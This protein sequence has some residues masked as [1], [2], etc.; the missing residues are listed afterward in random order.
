MSHT[1]QSIAHQFLLGVMER[2]RVKYAR[3]LHK[4]KRNRIKAQQGLKPADKDHL[5][6]ALEAET[7]A[8]ERTD[9]IIL[10]PG[11]HYSKV[12]HPVCETVFI[13]K[14]KTVH[15]STNHTNT[16]NSGGVLH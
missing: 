2:E 6:V 11:N 13:S 5:I 1:T 14:T 4:L 3:R 12:S 15:I 16:A 8:M 7:T 9:P 10:G